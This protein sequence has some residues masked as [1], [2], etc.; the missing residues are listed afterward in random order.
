MSIRL[1][2]DLEM[3]ALALCEDCAGEWGSK[4]KSLILSCS[5]DELASLEV[6]PSNFSDSESYFRAV[7]CVSFL[8][9]YEPLPTTV[10]RKDAAESNFWQSE[11]DC[12]RTNQRLLP[13]IFNTYL[14]EDKA[15]LDFL[16]DVRKEVEE[17]IGDRPPSNPEGRF[18]PGS[19]YGDK[20]GLTTIPDKMQSR[21]Q[22]TGSA[23]SYL[24]PWAGTLWAKACGNRGEEIEFV[25]GNRF[26]TVP[27]DCTKDRSIAI[28]PSINLFYQ[29]AYGRAMKQALSKNTAGRLH[30]KTAQSIHRQ[31]ACEASISG[32]FATIDLSR[33]SDSVCTS[34]VKL[35]LPHQWFEALDDL[36]SPA[37]LIRGAG[38]VDHWVL[39]EKFSSMGNGYTFE[40]ETVIFHAICKAVMKR[41]GTRPLSGQNVFTFGDDIIVPTAHA[42]GVIAALRYLGFE[43]NKRKT[44][45]SGPFR[46]SC[47]GDFFQGVGVRPYHQKK[48]VNEPQDYI[49]M[50]NG[51]RRMAASSSRASSRELVVRRAWFRCLDSIPVNI[52]RCRGPEELGDLVLHD[53]K[54]FWT[55]RTRGSVRYIRVYRPATHRKVKWSVFD[56]DVQL[57][58]LLYSPGS[59]GTFPS[60]F[61]QKPPGVT[62]R[63]S[64][65]GY[66]VGWVPYS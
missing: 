16:V 35:V 31:V 21:P 15:I 64:V 8:R 39:L 58:G 5:W 61:S 52:R 49:A 37:T 11:K 34:L 46:E 57:A 56:M 7:A 30:L 40:L 47:G 63:D 17:L 18:G 65:L 44:F 60:I 51:I 33:A 53:E 36:R 23:F 1:P 6:S 4:V 26:A 38:G 55:T 59:Y 2:R 54:E 42:E 45:V 22:L 48:E 62:P 29:L 41:E 25:R 19:T 43:T 20:G 12:Y 24:V 66:K 28:E 10:D 13:F 9:K 50:A 27:K 32:R 14:D 3:V